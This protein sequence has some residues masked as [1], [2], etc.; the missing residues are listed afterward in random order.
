MYICGDETIINHIKSNTDINAIK[1]N[2]SMINQLNNAILSIYGTNK[3]SKIKDY[4]N[5]FNIKSFTISYKDSMRINILTNN[6]NTSSLKQLLS[7]K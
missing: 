1:S 4:S 5:K 6:K 3:I 7:I 2:S